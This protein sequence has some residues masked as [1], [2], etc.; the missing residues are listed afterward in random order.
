M[1]LYD[2][3]PD[4]DEPLWVV[5]WKKTTKEAPIFGTL[6]CKTPRSNNVHKSIVEEVD[7]D[8]KI[9]NRTFLLWQWVLAYAADN[10]DEEGS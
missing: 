7:N 1:G 2:Q 8:D 9:H 5:V 10:L 3:I 4:C 6:L